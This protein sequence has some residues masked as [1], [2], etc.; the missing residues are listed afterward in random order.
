M[1][2]K[3]SDYALNKK[4]KEAIVFRNAAGGLIHLTKDEFASEE[5]FAKWKAW[6]DDEYRQEYNAG[7]SYKRLRK[8]M[9][10]QALTDE[11]AKSAEQILLKG[12]QDKE[13]KA[14]IAKIKASLTEKQ[15]RRL[16]LYYVEN[17]TEQQ[18]ADMEKT[19][20][21]AISLSI[22]RAIKKV[23]KFLKII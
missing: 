14:F 20:Q 23:K 3:K 8:K 2:D 18:I 13:R 5:E 6:S 17:K 19:S 21:Q 11:Y 1:Y 16:W 15:F 12:L 22:A 10:E 9:R 7:Q 4:N